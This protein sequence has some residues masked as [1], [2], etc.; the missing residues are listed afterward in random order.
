M[1]KVFF[2]FFP[3]SVKEL[4]GCEIKIEKKHDRIERNNRGG[5]Q[6]ELVLAKVVQNR[7]IDLK[8]TSFYV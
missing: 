3:G 7:T 2:S 1:G 8:E 4:G 6:W 5:T